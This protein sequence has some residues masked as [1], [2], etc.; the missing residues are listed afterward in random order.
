M[1]PASTG[2]APR[3]HRRDPALGE[4]VLAHDYL[5]QH[6]GAERVALELARIWP[7]APLYTALYRPQS[8]FAEFG[9]HEIRTSFVDRL[10]VDRGFRALLP[11][12][13]LAFESFP[14]V[15]ADVVICSSSAFAHGLRTSARAL[16]VVYCHTPARWLYGNDYLGRRS[17]REHAAKP[18]MGTLRRADRRAAQRAQLYV[19]N[20]QTVRRRI[21]HVYGIDARVVPPPVEVERFTP[22]PRGLRLLTVSRLL[23]Y[24]R[25]ELLI[26]AVNR[27]RVG[28][29]IVG[30]GPHRRHLHRIA[31]PTVT[32]QGA[33]P[34]EV[35]TELMETCSA[36]CL[37]GIED[38]GITPVEAQAAGKPV[39]AY[40]AGGALETVSEGLTGTFFSEPTAD[41]LIDAIRRLERLE[42]SPELI[43]RQAQRFSRAAFR[44]NL[45]SVIA[46]GM[47]GSDGDSGC[48]QSGSAMWRTAPVPTTTRVPALIP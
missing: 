39:V 26:A 3:P 34:D 1:N 47:Q 41:A 37:P 17:L 15:D 21:R 7:Q 10:P 14:P 36:Y 4:V 11:L 24:K 32:F 6:G 25:L 20:S 5:N 43:A 18:L 23:P 33:A 16:R 40:A 27:L 45:T 44:A 28:L 8:T 12:Y 13:P 48:T 38:F 2:Q 31:G 46:A 9:E 35:V 19:A 29:D 42:T 30:D 22:R